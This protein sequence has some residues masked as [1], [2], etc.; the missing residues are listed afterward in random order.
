MTAPDTPA[1]AP[2][3][4]DRSF[5]RRTSFQ[6][7]V[8][9]GLFLLWQLASVL[10]LAFAAVV[11]AVLLRAIADPIA[12][13]SPLNDGM[14]LAAACLVV[15]G[16][17]AVAGWLF[18][19]MLISQLWELASRLP[20]NMNQLRAIVASWP[21]GGDLVQRLQHATDLMTQFQ[22]LAGRIGGYAVSAF[23]AGANLILV[24]FTGLFLAVR[25]R[26]A[27]NGALLLAPKGPRESIGEALDASGRALRMWLL[28]MLAEMAA[29]GLL[30]GL[31][32][33]AVGLSSPL[34]LG[35]IA[36]V[37][38]FIP[39]VGSVASAVPGL[40]LA[41]PMWPHT[42][43]WTLLMYVA[44]QQ[45]EGNVIYP[46]IQRRAVDLPPALSM[47]VVLFFGVLLGP[48]GVMLA[49]PLLV[50]LLTTTKILYLRNTLGEQVRIPGSGEEGSPT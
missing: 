15:A 33:W 37:V 1:K 19:S 24:L 7:A 48:L 12:R 17:L 14:A 18:G 22:G 29:V 49:S 5:V 41:L 42:L 30:T 31:G 6:F 8:G 4:L 50:V 9:A 45:F 21:F 23:G 26:S 47:L 11:V 39:I 46:F 27:R 34:A 20:Q 44:V 3:A 38:D 16:L 10:L 40:L 13:R 35:V 2:P 32:A 43:L 25:P 28:G 36:G